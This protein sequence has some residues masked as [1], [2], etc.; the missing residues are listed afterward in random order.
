MATSEF[1]DEYYQQYTYF[2]TADLTADLDSSS[3]SED[4]NTYVSSAAD[5]A[6]GVPPI[7]CDPAAAL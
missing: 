1:V 4:G 7:V 3:C 5:P 2:G 6:S